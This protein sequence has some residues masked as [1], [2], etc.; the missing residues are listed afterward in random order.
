MIHRL[1]L[2]LPQP[3]VPPARRTQVLRRPTL[4]APT[5][6]SGSTPTDPDTASCPRTSFVHRVET[7]AAR[8][9]NPSVLRPSSPPPAQRESH[10]GNGRSSTTPSCSRDRTSRR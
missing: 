5:K 6:D 9:D 2:G 4:P 1:L 10:H 8:E 7:V 3:S